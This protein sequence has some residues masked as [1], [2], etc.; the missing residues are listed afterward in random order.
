MK[1]C[2]FCAEQIQ[3]DAV[4]CRY[5]GS[6]LGPPGPEQVILRIN[7]SLKLVIFLYAA[8]VA[9]GLVITGAVVWA[10]QSLKG[11]EIPFETVAI[12]FVVLVGVLSSSVVVV[13]IRRNSTHY[14]LTDRNLTISTGVFSRAAMHIPLH[15]VQDVSVRR[16]LLDR[17]LNLGTIVVESA[18]SAGRIPEINVDAP[19]RVCSTILEQVN[20]AKGN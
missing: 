3:D 8:C 5:C 12:T 7:P 9:A 10:G 19:V 18:G 17:I 20:S 1:K 11:G 15:K 2:P 4:K 14:I 13:H 16:T 6:Q